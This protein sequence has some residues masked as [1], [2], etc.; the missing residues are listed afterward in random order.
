M[1][2]PYTVTRATTIAAPIDTI[3]AL[4]VDFHNWPSWSPWEALDPDMRR[5]YSGPDVG[6]GA[7]YAWEGNKKAGKG[8]MAIT[9]VTDDRVDIDLEF[10]KP[11]PARSTIAFTLKAIDAD[12]TEVE[13]RLTG[14]L[15]LMMRAF[16]LVKSMDGLIGPD[17]EK[18][19]RQLKSVAES[20]RMP[21]GHPSA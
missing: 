18:G 14:E 21:G 17:F 7:R 6:V 2:T 1:P 12:R 8:W 9:G 13:W 19:L 16:S 3:H 10:L 4:L 20:G 11:F 15:N 5:T